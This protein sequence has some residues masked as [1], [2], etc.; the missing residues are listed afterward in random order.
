MRKVIV[1]LAALIVSLSS[2][3]LTQDSNN[4]VSYAGVKAA[5]GKYI[6]FAQLKAWG[7]ADG[8]L[9][10]DY[11]QIDEKGKRSSGS[12]TLADDS[13]KSVK[14]EMFLSYLNYLLKHGWI[15]YGYIG[16]NYCYLYKEVSNDS[17]VTEGIKFQK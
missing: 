3:A 5:P 10:F 4:L 14:G 9:T 12:R 8:I 15:L 17:E 16:D 6:V 7:G 1:L 2:I 11:G 13:G